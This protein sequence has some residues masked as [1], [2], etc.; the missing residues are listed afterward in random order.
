MVVLL[1]AYINIDPRSWGLRAIQ[2]P[3]LVHR[4][5]HHSSKSDGGN[6]GEDG[7]KIQKSIR[8]VSRGFDRLT[9]LPVRHAN[10]VTQGMRVAMG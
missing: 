7:S 1:R 6:L 3:I 8:S 10:S 5:V 2:N 4:L 9:T